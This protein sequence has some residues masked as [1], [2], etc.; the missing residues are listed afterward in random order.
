[1]HAHGR[2][3]ALTAVL[4]GGSSPATAHAW[5]DDP[6]AEAQPDELARSGCARALYGQREYV[7]AAR[8]YERLWLDVGTPKYLYNAAAAREAA[9]HPASALA[10][11]TRY[12]ASPGV[13]EEER[14]E[15]KQRLEEMRARLIA[16]TV[17]V[18]PADVL[19]PGATFW[20]ER[21]EGVP[22][23]SFDI[24]ARLI[25]GAAPGSFT[26]YLDPGAWELRLS[27]AS[28]LPEYTTASAP[29]QVTQSP[30]QLVLPLSQRAD[31]GT[32]AAPDRDAR[33]LTLGLGGASGGIALLGIIVLAV[34]KKPTPEMDTVVD[35][36]ESRRFLRQVGL[37]AGLVGAAIGL[38]AAAGLETL[39]ATR[40]RHHIQLGVG[41]GLAFGG[42]VLHLSFWKVYRDKTDRSSAITENGMNEQRA[43]RGISA[44]MLGAGAALMAGVGMSHLVRIYL[45]QRRQRQR[46]K[47]GGL[48][49]PHTI[50]FTLAGRF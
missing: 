34:A 45:P 38:G 14:A 39:A 29:M 26:L 50:G 3:Y 19:G 2:G 31:A 9:G 46:V 18:M 20:C 15:L 48:V 36:D 30:G 44:A 49:H 23:E 25:A 5:G 27:P 17:T 6:C 21:A 7:A 13:E 40:R 37:G 35:K 1:M 24:P 8:H 12:E 42:L 43:P 32:P 28:A 16:I 4:L 22:P 47:F 11:W 10:L 41:G 33:R